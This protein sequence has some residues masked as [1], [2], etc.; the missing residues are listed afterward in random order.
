[1]VFITSDRSEIKNL[2]KNEQDYEYGI[3]KLNNSI[4][5]KFML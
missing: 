4:I 1:M 5:R 2:Q 3:K